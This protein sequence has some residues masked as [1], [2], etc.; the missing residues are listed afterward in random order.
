M[1]PLWLKIIFILVLASIILMEIAENGHP[2]RTIAWILILIFL[3]VVGLILYFFF[4]RDRNHQR[5]IGEDDLKTLKSH[6]ERLYADQICHEAPKDFKELM[7][8]LHSTNS[9][10]PLS[11]NEAKPYTDFDSM[12][13]DLLEDLGAAR[14]NINFQFFKFEDD[15]MG[16][17]VAEILIR[18]AHEGLE[19]RLQYDDAVNLTR[20]GFY[21]RMRK[22]GVMVQPFI[23][24]RIP[25]L[26]SDTNYRNHRKNVI[27]DGR[28]GYT[29]G[30]N[31]A[32]R[33]ALGVHGGIWRD[34][35]VRIT[36][37]AV[38]ELQTAFLV[39]WQF[40]SKTIENTDRF[41]PQI[42]TTGNVL[43]QI[44]TAGPMDEYRVI[45]QGLVRIITNC[46]KYIYI[47]SPYF[48]PTEL[49]LMALR[50][51]ALSGVDIRIMLPYRGDRGIIVPAASRSYI[52]DALS[53]GVKVCFYEKGFMHS[54]AIVADDRIA[55]IGS[56]NIDIRSLEQ[57]FE[58]NAFIYD[59]GIA[60]KLRKAFEADEKCS[61]YI[62]PEEWSHR[63]VLK[64]FLESLARLFSPVL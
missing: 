53:A 7:T 63:P 42:E 49:V 30:M 8:L 24:I 50:N 22:E 44:A 56:T 2:V 47:Q 13:E 48:I 14:E 25:F 55:T 20:K 41:Y 58:I 31:I 23:K 16:Q 11:G 10:Y 59:R 29:G 27:I 26:S 4:G 39:D 51:A 38:S 54:K 43:M 28:I 19:V 40:S 9:A 5:L 36:G 45:M 21:R 12:F 6:T 64:R 33:Y 3:P 1:M 61:S 34:T 60:V 46:R 15:P 18:K 35:H 17:Q 37:P 62:D 57:D 52:K 32:D